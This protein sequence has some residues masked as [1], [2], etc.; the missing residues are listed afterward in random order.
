VAPARIAWRLAAVNE[1]IV[2]TPRAKTLVVDVPGSPGH[3]AAQHVDGR[4]TAEDGY[5]AQRSYAIASAPEAGDADQPAIDLTI[6]RFGDGEVSPY[7]T[8]ELGPGDE[9]ELRGPI[10][11]PLPRS[12]DEGGPLYLIA[13]GSG[14]VRLMAML[15]HPAAPQAG[16]GRRGA[17]AR[18][19]LQRDR[20]LPHRRA[21]VAHTARTAPP[22]LDLHAPGVR[23]LARR[24]PPRGRRDA[25]RRRPTRRRACSSTKVTT[26]ARSAPR[27]SAPKTPRSG[28]AN[29]VEPKCRAG[30]DSI[31]GGAG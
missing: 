12:V 24:D 9:L 16:R 31:Q 28:A 2:E 4:L 1:V 13:C 23:P 3:V 15:R 6:E 5:Q 19:Q 30:E 14:I 17:R 25:A 20:R 27:T 8:D 11:G 21:G 18:L 26:R 10:G 29:A 7:L 22:R